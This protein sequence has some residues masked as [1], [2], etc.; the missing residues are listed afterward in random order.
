MAK[1]WIILEG[2]GYENRIVGVCSSKKK[3]DLTLS[4]MH[5]YLGRQYSDLS[6]EEQEV[7]KIFLEAIN[8]L[9]QMHDFYKKANELLEKMKNES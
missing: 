1:V 8:D 4:S 3:A 5:K 9:E 2:D 6:I 7:D